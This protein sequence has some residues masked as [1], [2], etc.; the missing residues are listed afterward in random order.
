MFWTKTDLI[1]HLV[2]EPTEI[3]S[4]QFSVW[5]G[6]PFWGISP[7]FPPTMVEQRPLGGAGSEAAAEAQTITSQ[8]E[9]MQSY[10]D[11]ARRRFPNLTIDLVAKEGE[12]SKHLGFTVIAD[13]IFDHL[14]LKRG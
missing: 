13:I 10:S 6:P 3:S 8:D 1:D 14:K 2:R 5:A 9:I 11:V 7:F 4:E 12:K